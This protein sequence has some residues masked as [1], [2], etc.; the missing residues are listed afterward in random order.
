MVSAAHKQSYVETSARLHA[1]SSVMIN[2][3]QN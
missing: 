2:Y 1:N 3:M